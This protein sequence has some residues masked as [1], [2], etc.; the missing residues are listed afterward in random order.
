VAIVQGDA[1]TAAGEPH[2]WALAAYWFSLNFQGSALLTIVVPS[3]LQGMARAD[4]T[5]A[6]ARLAALAAVLSMAVPPVAGFI[7]DRLRQTGI[8]RRPFVVG[9]AALNVVG[10]IVAMRAHALSGL[11]WGLLVAVFGQHVASATYH[12]MMPEVVRPERW[13]QASG[14]MGVATLAGSVAGMGI[15]GTLPLAVAYLA[16]IATSGAG[17]AVTTLVPEQPRLR[18]TDRPRA[19]VRSWRRF[20]WVFASRFL[21]LFAQTLLMT[22]VLYFF[23]DVLRV[24]DAAGGTAAVAVLA[25]IGAAASAFYAGRLSDAV[26][27]A[28]VVAAAGVPM[29]LAV[30]GFALVP[31]PSLVFVLAV[32]W[33][34][35][36]GAFLSVDWALALDS[37]PD[38]ANVARDLGVWGIA[39]NLPAVVA[40][41]VGAA[42]LGHFAAAAV[43]YRLLF[44]TAA[45]AF[46][47][48][49]ALVLVG[50]EPRAQGQR[51]VDA[52]APVS[53]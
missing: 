16:M 37:V 24:R 5:V 42:I 25:L 1:R 47:V 44:L 29:A 43:G 17:A 28:G 32:V 23:E 40:P 6:L 36:Y 41:V 2:P 45:A 26:D 49:S 27:R 31:E 33:G 53:P 34:V 7:S 4:R 8:G 22:F 52:E 14:H 21:V 20:S 9:G 10:L 15:A 46:A 38:L 11:T 35:G 51:A 13:G 18:P 3:V 39:T 48:G 19:L 12:A 30:A 50:R